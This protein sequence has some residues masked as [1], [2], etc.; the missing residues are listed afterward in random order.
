ML[1]N[2]ETELLF[3]IL[4]KYSS[5]LILICSLPVLCSLVVAYTWET[6]RHPF[7]RT[8]LE[9]KDTAVTELNAEYTQ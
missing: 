3:W 6:Y 2:F 5:F 9:F 4:E 7:V 8:L 1:Y